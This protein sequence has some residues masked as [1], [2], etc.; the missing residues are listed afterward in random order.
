MYSLY[1]F[2]Q[3]IG[4]LCMVTIGKAQLSAAPW[5]PFGLAE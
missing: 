4:L 1:L 5:D 2:S 3:L